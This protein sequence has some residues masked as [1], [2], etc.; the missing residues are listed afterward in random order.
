MSSVKS[1]MVGL[2]AGA[3][4][5][6]SVAHAEPVLFVDKQSQEVQTPTVP[7][8]G[9]SYVQSSASESTLTVY[10]EGFLFCGNPGGGTNT[11]MDLVVKHEDQTMN[12]PQSWVF[13]KSSDL[14]A[15]TYT[16]GSLHLNPSQETSLMC[17][18]STADGA[19]ASSTREGIF[20]NGYDS[21]TE[22]NYN[23]LIN[24]IPSVGFDW[25]APDWSEVPV[26][27]CS[28]DANHPARVVEDVGC[29]AVTAVRPSAQGG[30]TPT[31]ASRL[32]TYTDGTYLVYFFQ[33]D[34]R[35]G[36]QTSESPVPLAANGVDPSGGTVNSSGQLFFTVRDAFDSKY[37]N[38]STLNAGD[39]YCVLPDV[40]AVLDSNVCAGQTFTPLSGGKPLEISD[41]AGGLSGSVVHSYVAVKRRVVGGHLTLETPV[42][43]VS[44]LV[45]RAGVGEGADKFIGDNVVFGFMPTSGGFGWMRGNQ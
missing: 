40:P 16:D 44:I 43:G 12:P 32:W 3:V 27:P 36:P 26:A 6:G 20:D 19:M 37:L 25:D 11:P 5:C 30:N 4:A 15:L 35:F 7:E 13:S 10:T 42:V 17:L 18:S 23:R 31:R 14:P 2:A 38:N 33:V 8:V 29:A 1:W 9:F 41:S 21:A 34:V 22:I 39:G 45:E 24:W 28:P